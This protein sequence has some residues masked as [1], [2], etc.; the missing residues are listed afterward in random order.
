MNSEISATQIVPPISLCKYP[1]CYPIAYS[2]ADVFRPGWVHTNMTGAADGGPKPQGAW[3][4][5]QTV[6]YMVD[7]VFEEGDFYVICPDN[8][9]SSVS[10]HQLK[11]PSHP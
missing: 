2:S 7:R 8:E 6:D 4:P 5:E 10:Q 1:E 3:T 11:R 9:T